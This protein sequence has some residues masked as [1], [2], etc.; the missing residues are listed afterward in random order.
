MTHHIFH[1]L[2]CPQC[3]IVNIK[4]LQSCNVIDALSYV[5]DHTFFQTENCRIFMKSETDAY[6]KHGKTMKTYTSTEY[7]HTRIPNIYN[8]HPDVKVH[9]YTGIPLCS[10]EKLI[11]FCVF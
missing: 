2:A 5:Q 9:N 4:E 7:P 1:F 3:K 10:N 11:Y 8:R 6:G